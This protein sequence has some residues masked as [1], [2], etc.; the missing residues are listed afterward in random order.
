MIH[1]KWPFSLVWKHEYFGSYKYS[2]PGWTDFYNDSTKKTLFSDTFINNV[3]GLWVQVLDLFS[4]SMFCIFIVPEEKIIPMKLS[5]KFDNHIIEDMD[6][7]T[8]FWSM[9]PL[10]K[11]FT[12]CV[13]FPILVIL[14]M[15]IL[16]DVLRLTWVI[17]ENSQILSKSNLGQNR[18]KESMRSSLIV[19]WMCKWILGSW[20][21]CNCVITI[22][23]KRHA[24]SSVNSAFLEGFYNGRL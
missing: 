22:L 20:T 4:M 18:T 21:L 7:N 5:I 9:I 11:N 24:E 10:S 23:E 2:V 19:D 8:V 3:T 16:Y 15:K 1:I 17:K 13:Y 14:I 12:F 6:K